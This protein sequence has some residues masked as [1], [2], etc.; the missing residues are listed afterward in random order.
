MEGLE[1]M[2]VRDREESEERQHQKNQKTSDL[3][4]ALTKI[5][6]LEEE[7]KE[8]KSQLRVA[9]TKVAAI[10]L[11]CRVA[12]QKAAIAEVSSLPAFPLTPSQSTAAAAILQA[13][14]VIHIPRT[15]TPA[16]PTREEPVTPVKEKNTPVEEIVSSP[17]VTPTTPR[18]ALVTVPSSREVRP[19]LLNEGDITL[20]VF[21][22]R[23]CI[24]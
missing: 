24:P 16:T 13:P 17:P 18:R 12:E 6:K 14:Q 1:Y 23:S 20:N 8:C 21:R 2:N 15:E 10:E 11:R 19:S 5:T 7:L 4:E 3:I 22:Y 9:E